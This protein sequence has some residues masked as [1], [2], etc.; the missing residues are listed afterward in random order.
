MK[1]KNNAICLLIGLMALFGTAQCNAWSWS[2]I[3][4]PCSAET[5]TITDPA[6]QD[7]ALIKMQTSLSDAQAYLN[8]I[9][10]TPGDATCLKSANADIAVLKQMV[11]QN[12]GGDFKKYFLAATPDQMH[13]WSKQEQEKYLNWVKKF[14]F[15]KAQRDCF[16]PAAT[17]THE[18]RDGVQQVLSPLNLNDRTNLNNLIAAAA[19]EKE[20]LEK[21]RQLKE[22][23]AA[24]AEKERLEKE[25]QLKEQ[26]AAAAEK[27]RL[28][29]ERQLKEQAAAAAEAEQKRQEEVEKM[30][31][32][33]AGTMRV[34]NG[35][36]VVEGEPTL[37]DACAVPKAP[38][39]AVAEDLGM[40]LKNDE[41]KEEAPTLQEASSLPP[42][43]LSPA[44]GGSYV[45]VMI[46]APLAV[47]L[48]G[49]ATVVYLIK[50]KLLGKEDDKVVIWVNKLTGKENNPVLEWARSMREKARAAWQSSIVAAAAQKDSRILK[51]IR[52]VGQRTKTLWQNHFATT[53][54]Q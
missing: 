33:E 2:K 22:Q 54:A 52:H 49:A 10:A 35:S 38:A 43:A 28:E 44:I 30:E 20:R 9:K 39:Y 6:A 23:A 13:Q 29:K 14:K 51:W 12:G 16:G 45:K 3:Y 1:N 42:T 48:L 47:A 26:A 50:N 15:E 19:A 11:D 5:P 34:I 25:R 18:V 40:C 21:E 4:H 41:Q 31:P 7:R 8:G 36:T 53:T 46:A 27:E 17:I 24:A 32:T 37:K